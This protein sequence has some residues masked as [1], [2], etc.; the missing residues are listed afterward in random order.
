MAVKVV[1]LGSSELLVDVA[2]DGNLGVLVV[3]QAAQHW[4][5]GGLGASKGMQGGGREL[6]VS[7][8]L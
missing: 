8:W 7:S 3:V 1:R 2:G 6:D 4:N 5:V